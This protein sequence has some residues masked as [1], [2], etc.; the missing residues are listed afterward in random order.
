M[1]KRELLE[2]FYQRVWIGGDTALATEMFATQGKAEGMVTGMAMGGV[3]FGTIVE[4]FMA[5]LE[6]PTYRIDRTVEEGDWLSAL[7]TVEAHAASDGRPVSF[8]GQ[9]M[10][11]YT[12]GKVAEAYNHFDYVTLFEQLGLLPQDALVMFLSGAAVT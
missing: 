8:N 11:R 5:L 1:T 10:L 9:I 7:V 6:E 4:A 2:A 3:D 12:D